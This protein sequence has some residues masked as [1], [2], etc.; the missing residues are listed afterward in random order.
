MDKIEMIR[1]LK[2]MQTQTIIQREALKSMLT[3]AGRPDLEDELLDTTVTVQNHI[4][5]LQH[6]IATLAA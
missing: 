3:Q 1:A 4:A 2:A 6:A 5:S